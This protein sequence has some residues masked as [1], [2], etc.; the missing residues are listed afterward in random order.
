MT[1]MDYKDTYDKLS[2]IRWD[3][4]EKKYLSGLNQDEHER[5]GMLAAWCWHYKNLAD[6]IVKPS[7]HTK[8]LERCARLIA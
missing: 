6:K 7:L 3:L 1:S 2:Q 4:T 5:L 8:K